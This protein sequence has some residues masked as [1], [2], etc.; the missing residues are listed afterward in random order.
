MFGFFKSAKQTYQQAQT[1]QREL[2]V[3]FDALGLN[4]MQLDPVVHGALMKEAMVLGTE[5]AVANFVKMTEAAQNYEG[6]VTDD[7][8]AN[9]FREYYRARGEKFAADLK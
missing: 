3:A 1:A 9:V 6:D 8:K 5:A 2:T 4:F 7:Q